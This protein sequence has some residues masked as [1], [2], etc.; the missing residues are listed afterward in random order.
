MS[1]NRF[2]SFALK[3]SRI[4]IGGAPMSV[5]REIAQEIVQLSSKTKAEG[6]PPEVYTVA[7]GAP[8]VIG[9]HTTIINNYYAPCDRSAHKDEEGCSGP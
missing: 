4:T 1:V 6:A 2:L 7:G 8:I 3:R 5:T 9:D